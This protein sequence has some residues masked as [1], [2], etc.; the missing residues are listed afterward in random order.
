M[1]SLDSVNFKKVDLMW[2]KTCSDVKIWTFKGAYLNRRWSWRQFSVIIVQLYLVTVTCRYLLYETAEEGKTASDWW[3]G[4]VSSER[5]V[6]TWIQMN[7]HDEHSS[8]SHER[9]LFG[10]LSRTEFFPFLYLFVFKSRLAAVCTS[11]VFPLQHKT[12]N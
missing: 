9:N 11:H 8:V 5:K 12:S 4:L 10:R 3:C 2:R 6:R 7:K 1:A